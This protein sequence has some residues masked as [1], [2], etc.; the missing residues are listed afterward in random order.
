MKNTDWYALFVETGKENIV[1]D[2]VRIR[3]KQRGSGV[4]CTTLVPMVDTVRRSGGENHLVRKVMFPGYV[5]VET[6]DINNLFMAVKD[7]RFLFSILGDGKTFTPIPPYEIAPIMY[8]ADDDGII[9]SSEVYLEGDGVKAKSGPL[10]KYSGTVLRVDKRLGRAIV[11]FHLCGRVFEIA[12]AV[13]ILERDAEEL[14]GLVPM[15]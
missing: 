1:Q 6:D 5:F 10:A 15:H 7:C 4:C 11:R 14:F 3:L 2:D 9:G 13:K 8:M 12:L